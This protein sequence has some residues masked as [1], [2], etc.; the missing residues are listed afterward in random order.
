MSSIFDLR[1]V[2]GM[3]LNEVLL[4]YLRAKQLLLI[5]DNCEHLVESSARIVDQIL[6]T[7]QQVRIIA[8]SREALGISG[9]TV[10]PC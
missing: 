1:E 8:S 6:H 3:P 4:D 7:C 5:V 9:E 10:P 2:P